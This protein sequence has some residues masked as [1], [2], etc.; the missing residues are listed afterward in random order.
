MRA[1]AIYGVHWRFCDSHS[2]ASFLYIIFNAVRCC[3]LYFGIIL[4]F[5][6][7]NYTFLH[8]LECFLK[9]AGVHFLLPIVIFKI[10]FLI[11]KM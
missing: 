6:Y 11:S 3:Q 5:K 9:V 2:L 4:L 8:F 1:L 10:A 7:F